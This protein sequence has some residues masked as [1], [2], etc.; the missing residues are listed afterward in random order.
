MSLL[1]RSQQLNG[2]H[3]WGRSRETVDE[4][5]MKKFGHPFR[6]PYEDG[7]EHRFFLPE[8]QY[9]EFIVYHRYTHYQGSS[10]CTTHPCYCYQGGHLCWMCAP[11]NTTSFYDLKVPIDPER[12]SEL[13][14]ILQD[15][16]QLSTAQMYNWLSFWMHDIFPKRY[17]Y[18]TMTPVFFEYRQYTLSDKI[19]TNYA[20]MSFLFDLLKTKTNK[21][22]YKELNYGNKASFEIDPSNADRVKIRTLKALL[23]WS[24]E[25][26]R[27]DT[28]I[29]G[30]ETSKKHCYSVFTYSSH[31]DHDRF[32]KYWKQRFDTCTSKI[33][34]HKTSTTQ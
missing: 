26:Y 25:V 13:K 33:R 20:F 7:D 32:R 23:K 27:Q 24:I 10:H 22:K 11:L 17:S 2:G 29:I 15:E 19:R 14:R 12:F 30:C 1:Y 3:G 31:D 16:C 9:G 8:R 18:D 5:S 21:K 4:R 28:Y 6:K 34:A